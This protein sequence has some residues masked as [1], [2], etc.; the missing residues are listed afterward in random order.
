[1]RC[2]SWMIIDRRT[3]KVIREIWNKDF[4]SNVINNDKFCIISSYD[5]LIHYNQ[6]VKENNGCEPTDKQF[7]NRWKQ[8]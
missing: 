7:I 5:W 1:M 6:L 2:N 8:R 3:G 4:Y